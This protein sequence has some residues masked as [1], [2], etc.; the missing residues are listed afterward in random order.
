MSTEITVVND[1][2]EINVTEEV[3]VIEAPS[4]AYPLP[5]GVYSVYGRTGNVVAQDGDYNLLS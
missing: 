3:I 4:G 5:T 2:V 1:I